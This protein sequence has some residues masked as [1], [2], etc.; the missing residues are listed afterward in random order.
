[1]IRPG[2]GEPIEDAPPIGPRAATIH[3]TP[4]AARF[5]ERLRFADSAELTAR[6]VLQLRAAN[7]NMVATLVQE[8]AK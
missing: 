1:M 7:L 2:W 4:E 5:I 3:V 6:L 8:L